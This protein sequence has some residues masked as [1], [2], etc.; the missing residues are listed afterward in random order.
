[1]FKISIRLVVLF[2]LLSIV[3]VHS[4]NCIERSFG[5]RDRGAEYLN[6]ILK[7]VYVNVHFIRDENGQRNFDEINGAIF[8]QNIIDNLNFLYANNIEVTNS[9]SQPSRVIDT[10]IQFELKAQTGDIEDPDQDGVYFWN[11]QG[12]WARIRDPLRNKWLIWTR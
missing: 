10:K 11:S 8:A 1:M 6:T 2:H 9:I 12:N 3:S 7:T 4:Q 5:T